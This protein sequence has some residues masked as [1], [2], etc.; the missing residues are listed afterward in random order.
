MIHK[1]YVVVDMTCVF[2]DLV[3]D[4]LHMFLISSFILVMFYLY[5]LM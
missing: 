4:I 3:P 5:K 2:F 1:L